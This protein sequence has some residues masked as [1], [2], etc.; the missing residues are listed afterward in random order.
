MRACLVSY[1][2][3]MPAEKAKAF[4]TAWEEKHKD[5]DLRIDTRKAWRAKQKSA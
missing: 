5:F 1:I 2:A 4:L 3:A